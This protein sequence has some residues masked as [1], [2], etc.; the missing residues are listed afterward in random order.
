MLHTAPRS[1]LPCRPATSGLLRPTAC[2]RL[3]RAGCSVHLAALLACPVRHLAVQHPPG[4]STV[5]ARGHTRARRCCMCGS[6][7]FSS[8][9]FPFP[10]CWQ[11]CAPS[12]Y[13]AAT[14]LVAAA[15]RGGGKGPRCRGRPPA[16]PVQGADLPSGPG[17]PPA[18]RPGPRRARPGLPTPAGA[19]RWAA[20]LTAA[21]VGAGLTVLYGSKLS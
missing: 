21:C 17:G 2:R 1:T 4:T 14:L 12:A 6:H 8:P 7:V 15:C 11:R 5:C 20:S 10:A 18:P 9:P 3:T 16:C 13:S 19:S